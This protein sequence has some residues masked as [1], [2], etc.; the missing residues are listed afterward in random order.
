MLGPEQIPESLDRSVLNIL[1]SI[2]V[3]NMHFKYLQLSEYVFEYMWCIQEY[4]FFA[5]KHYL[6]IIV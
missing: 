5:F 4:I 6:I 1:I 3:I 2:P